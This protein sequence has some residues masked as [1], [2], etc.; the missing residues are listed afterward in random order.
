MDG[1]A[2]ARDGSSVEDAR[3]AVVGGHTAGRA[4]GRVLGPRPQPVQEPPVVA[5]PVITAPH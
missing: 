2:D 3:V 1:P 4:Y 5:E